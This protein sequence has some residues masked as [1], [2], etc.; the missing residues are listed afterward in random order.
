MVQASLICCAGCSSERWCTSLP[1]CVQPCPGVSSLSQYVYPGL[2]NRGCEC[3]CES[4]STPIIH[5]V[6]CVTPMDQSPVTARVVLCDQRHTQIDLSGRTLGRPYIY[7]RDRNTEAT[8]P[9][10]YS[11][12]FRG[13]LIHTGSTASP[14]TR[15]HRPSSGISPRSSPTALRPWRL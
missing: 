13:L 3:E 8:K 9:R 7:C 2:L 11:N 5:H 12:P 10:E 4:P 1:L 6:I 15:P 14:D